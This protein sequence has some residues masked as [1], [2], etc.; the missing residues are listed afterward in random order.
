MRARKGFTIL[1]VG[2]A[3]H[4][5]AVGTLAVAPDAIRL[6][7]HD[8]RPRRA[9]S[10]DGRRP[11][12]VALLAQTTLAHERVG[13]H[14]STQHARAF[15]ELWTASRNDLCFATTNRQAALTAIAA[16]GRRGRRDRQRQLVEHDR[17]RE[18]RARRRAARSCCASTVPTSSTS[19]ALGDAR[20]RRRDRGRER[21][22]GSRRG[23]DRRARARPT[24]SSRCASPTRTS[25]SRRRA[26]CASSIPALDAVAAFAF[27]GDPARTRASAGGPLRRRPRPRRV[28]GARQRSV[29]SRRRSREFVAPRRTPAAARRRARAVSASTSARGTALVVRGGGTIGSPTTIATRPK[30]GIGA[31]PAA[32]DL[33]GAR[34]PD[35]NDRHA[36]AQREVR[37]ARL[38]RLD[39]RAVLARAF[40]E[41]ASRSPAC[42]IADR[43]AH[44]LAVGAVARDREPAERT[45]ERAEHRDLEHARPCP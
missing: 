32:Q 15:P 16:A 4:D 7:E 30:R 45:E 23:G 33:L 11:A 35:R 27:G 20:D 1:Y 24:A 12:K 6:V 18:G 9:C 2:H 19:T 3:G 41:H 28:R 42:S 43:V 34:H 29:A 36:G 26:S 17:A 14:R 39:L 40:G 5:E 13:R 10:R 25:T 44:R 37:G 22:R 38:Q 31:R 21:A 8:D